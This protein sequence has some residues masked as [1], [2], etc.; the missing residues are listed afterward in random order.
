MNKLRKTFLLLSLQEQCRADRQ[1]DWL[2]LHHRDR[3]WFLAQPSQNRWH[4]AQNWLQAF[5]SPPHW[6][7]LPSPLLIVFIGVLLGVGLMS[8]LLEFQSHQRINIWWWLLL[9]VWLP[10]LWWLLG[11]W[12]GRTAENSIWAKNLISRL[13]S[14]S[15]GDVNTPLL[16]LT[17]QAM[18]QQVSLGF[19]LG[20]AGTFFIYLLLSDLAFGWSSTLDVTSKAVHEI[21]QAL[22][23]PWSTLWPGAVPSLELV[24]QS[25]FFRAENTPSASAET[26][27]HWWRFLLMNLLCYVVAPRIVSFAWA[28]WQLSRA[29][30]RLFTQDACIDGWWQRLHFEE[31]RQH[32]A[33]APRNQATPSLEISVSSENTANIQA[34]APWPQLDGIVCAGRWQSDKLDSSVALLPPGVRS[35]PRLPS[36]QLSGHVSPGQAFLLLCKGWEPPTGSIAD[37]CQ[38]MH[39]L[40]VRLY[41]WPAPLPGMKKERTNQLRESWQLFVPQLPPSCHLL[42]VRNHV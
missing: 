11:L 20:L 41:I 18:S 28:E 32:A 21:V 12:L 34:D 36:D 7:M 3:E 5:S 15:P 38:R 35:L 39:E 40:Q 10:V 33:P 29:Q 17:A 22:S 4:L 31:V 26:A 9:A 8:G 27:G 37:L 16:R 30:E 23:K 42:D 1:A 14:H 25:R 19:A 13:P 2:S 24:E 6:R